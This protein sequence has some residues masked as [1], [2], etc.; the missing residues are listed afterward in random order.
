M[1]RDR[2]SRNLRIKKSFRVDFWGAPSFRRAAID[3]L[4]IFGSKNRFASISWAWRRWSRI[5]AQ[6]RSSRE[7]G[8]RVAL[9]AQLS[10]PNLDHLTGHENRSIRVDPKQEL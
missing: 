4:Q 5:P 1:R 10:A 9:E 7:L 2:R 3:D 6:A 8:R